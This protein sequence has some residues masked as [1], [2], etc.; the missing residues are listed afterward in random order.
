MKRDRSAHLD[1][2]RCTRAVTRGNARIARI[3]ST[4]RKYARPNRRVNRLSSG[5]RKEK[6]GMDSKVARCLEWAGNREM[7]KIKQFKIFSNRLCSEI[8]LTKW[9]SSRRAAR[10][11][12]PSRGVN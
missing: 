12:K 8:V 6:R 5:E 10:A 1:A 2:C 9:R 3:A 11:K 4:I 7:E